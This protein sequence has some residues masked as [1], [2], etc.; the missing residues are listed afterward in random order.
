MRVNGRNAESIGERC[1]ETDKTIAGPHGRTTTHVDKGALFV[2]PFVLI[3]SYVNA[4]AYVYVYV[5]VLV[6]LRR[7]VHGH[8]H[9]LVLVH[10]HALV[11]VYLHAY[12]SMYTYVCV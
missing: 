3:R 7:H 11:H 6:N 1:G 5:I 4:H 2:C 10:V 12:A 8:V 9:A